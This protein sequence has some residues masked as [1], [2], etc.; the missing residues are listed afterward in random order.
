V[1]S[2]S[3]DVNYSIVPVLVLID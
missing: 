1:A 3:A 2:V